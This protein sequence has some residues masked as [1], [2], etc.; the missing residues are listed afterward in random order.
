MNSAKKYNVSASECVIG[1]EFFKP[2]YKK[3]FE[4]RAAENKYKLTELKAKDPLLKILL[5][6]F[7][8]YFQI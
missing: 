3:D 7:Y 4:R 1:L 8:K 2:E 5:W 6:L